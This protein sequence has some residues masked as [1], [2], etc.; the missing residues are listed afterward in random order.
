MADPSGTTPQPDSIQ[1]WDIFVRVF[2]WTLAVGFFVAYFSEDVQL[3]HVWTGYLIGVLVLARIIWG[4]VGPQH[5]RFS[6][7]AFPLK[8]VLAYL[9]DLVRFKA[10]RHI[11]HSPAGAVMVWA[12]LAGLLAIVGSGLVLYA[13][14][15]NAG[16]L[17][18]FVS[19]DE[20]NQG[21]AP[22]ALVSTAQA[23]DDDD[24]EHAE[25]GER[26][27]AGERAGEGYAERGSGQREAHEGAEELWE[28][29]HE[30]F[31]N[32]VLIL[33]LLHIV[34]VVFASIVT[35]ENLPRSMVTG[36]KRPLGQ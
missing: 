31:A 3:L 8:A 9:I 11:G 27:K 23:D 18:G 26:G 30:V 34:G 16:P 6:D 20:F 28:E 2:H 19:T 22:F 5:A 14:E 17:A 4:F 25:R 36:R 7:F 35:R 13:L 15:E 12:L 1:V 29:L 21:A 33:V 32:L 10:I 24:E